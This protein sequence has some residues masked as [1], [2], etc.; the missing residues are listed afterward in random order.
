MSTTDQVEKFLKQGVISITIGISPNK[1]LF[2]QATHPVITGSQGNHMQI[3]HQAEAVSLEGCLNQ[4][5]K[6]VDHANELKPTLVQLPR[7]NG[8]R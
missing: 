3:V 2:V 4:I 7:G 5:S 8:G 1:M 6:Q